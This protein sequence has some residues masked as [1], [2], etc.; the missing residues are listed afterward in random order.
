MNK[1]QCGTGGC[2]RNV[3]LMMACKTMTLF[4]S[5][6]D[7]S[8]DRP[9]IESNSFWVAARMSGCQISST[10]THSTVVDV[11]SVPPLN[12]SC[13]PNHSFNRSFNYQVI[14]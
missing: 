4:K 9:T 7:T 12:K 11:V 10:S 2:C 6:S 3:S 14:N 8:V 5:S 13:K 1:S